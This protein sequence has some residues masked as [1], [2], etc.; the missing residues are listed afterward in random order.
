ML[1][2]ELIVFPRGQKI[3]VHGDFLDLERLIANHCQILSIIGV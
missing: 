1:E 2:I 3:T